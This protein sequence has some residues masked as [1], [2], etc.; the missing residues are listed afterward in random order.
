M[1]GNAPVYRLIDAGRCC[2]SS[3]GDKRLEAL[4]LVISGLCPMCLFRWLTGLGAPDL[5][6][7]VRSRS[8]LDN[9]PL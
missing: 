5:V 4:W 3:M 1:V 8:D 7:A 9:G 2:P 6:A